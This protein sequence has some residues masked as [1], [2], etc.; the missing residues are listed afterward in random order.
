MPVN[1]IA[2]SVN[3]K[4]VRG[5]YNGR[6]IDLEHIGY[7]LGSYRVEGNGDGTMTVVFR[8]LQNHRH[9][10]YVWYQTA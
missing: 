5:T 7:R 4:T 1:Y 3:G 10:G 8:L 2:Q 9:I 6:P